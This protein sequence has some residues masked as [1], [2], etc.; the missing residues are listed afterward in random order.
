MQIATSIRTLW[1][2]FRDAQY[3]NFPSA[4]SAETH[5]ATLKLK[6]RKYIDV[7]SETNPFE[8]NVWWRPSLF[9]G[10]HMGDEV[11]YCLQ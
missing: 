8:N 4:G 3:G 2:V 6:P 9:E 1:I 7:R 5:P 10:G 11:L